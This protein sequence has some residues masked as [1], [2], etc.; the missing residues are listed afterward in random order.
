MNKINELIKEHNLTKAGIS[1]AIE[2]GDSGRLGNYASKRRKVTVDVG[3][4]IVSGFNKLGVNCTF[5][6]I[7]PDPNKNKAA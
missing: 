7:F 3:Y 6:D 5:E 1:R 4:E 2:W